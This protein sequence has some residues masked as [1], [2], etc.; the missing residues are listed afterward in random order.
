MLSEAVKQQIEHEAAVLPDRRAAAIEG[1]R[2][3]QQERGWISDESLAE[4]AAHLELSVAELEGLATFY[5]LIHRRQVGRHVIRVCDSVSCWLLGCDGLLRALGQQLRVAPGETTADGRFTLLPTQCL[6]D[7]DHAPALMIDEDLHH[8]V[9]P[10]ALAE[11]LE[12]Y[13]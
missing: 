7:C 10:A 3:L 11:L 4:L 1:L 12:R 6:G 13:R 5:E 8:D 2:A 9:Q